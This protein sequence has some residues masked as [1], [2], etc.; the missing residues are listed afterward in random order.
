LE[1]GVKVSEEAVAVDEEDDWGVR[2]GGVW[3]AD[4]RELKN[5]D[6]VLEVLDIEADALVSFSSSPRTAMMTLWMSY[7]S[8]GHSFIVWKKA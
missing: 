4:V 1:P 5:V 2:I 7:I 8:V 3:R 6:V